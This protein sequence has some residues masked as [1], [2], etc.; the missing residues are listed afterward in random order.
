MDRS[1]SQSVKH[2]SNIGVVIVERQCPIRM[3]RAGG[4]ARQVNEKQVMRSQVAWV[5]GGN[6][7]HLWRVGAS[8]VYTL[9]ISTTVGN[10]DSFPNTSWSLTSLSRTGEGHSVSLGSEMDSFPSSLHEAQRPKP[11]HS[12]KK[13]QMAQTAMSFWTG[14]GENLYIY[15]YS[16][17]THLGVFG[18]K[19][20]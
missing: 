1:P 9:Q 16:F 17:T 14:G 19:T 5:L 3:L 4:Q 7:G 20:L 15:E 8:L 6:L 13:Q 12:T 11:V 18:V 10:S 2:S